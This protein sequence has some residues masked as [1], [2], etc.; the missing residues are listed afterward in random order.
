MLD[1]FY[2]GFT[3][4]HLPVKLCGLHILLAKPMEHVPSPHR[5][6]MLSLV[7]PSDSG[8]AIYSREAESQLT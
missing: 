4:F 3:F 2:K 8:V 5:N 7:P 6:T 1:F